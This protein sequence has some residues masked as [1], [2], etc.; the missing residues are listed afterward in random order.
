MRDSAKKIFRVVLPI[1]VLLVSSH[2]LAQEQSDGD[3]PSEKKQDVS[4][5]A[6]DLADIIPKVTKLSGDLATLDNRVTGVLD[7]SELE[8]K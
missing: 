5:S 7:I 6:P 3:Q 1:T 2:V 4:V 8:E